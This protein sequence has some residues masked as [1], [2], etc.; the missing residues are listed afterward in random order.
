VD[1]SG[2]GREVGSPTKRK[3]K[4]G[5]RGKADRRLKKGNIIGGTSAMGI[6]IKRRKR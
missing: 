5:T 6:G 3:I 1:G 4:K 2:K